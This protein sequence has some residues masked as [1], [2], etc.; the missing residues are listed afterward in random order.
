MLNAVATANA[1]DDHDD[2]QQTITSGFLLLAAL[3]SVFAA[4]L[5]FFLPALGRIVLESGLP[6][7]TL[8]PAM[9]G[10]T[11]FAVYALLA[12]PLTTGDRIATAL[13][14]G[15]VLNLI[16]ACILIVTV[17]AV[18]AVIRAGGG[19]VSLC[20]A[21]ILPGL[22]GS[23]M[24]WLIVT[25]NR[26]WLLPQI[27]QFTWHRSQA[28]LHSGIGFFVIQL[29]GAIG[30]N[31]DTLIVAKGLGPAAAAE[32][33]L[34]S[35][36]FSIALVIGNI[37]LSP[38]WPAYAD[39]ASRGELSWARRALTISLV[40]SAGLGGFLA[41]SLFLVSGWL[42]P[43]WL[44]DGYAVNGTLVAMMAVWTTLSLVGTAIAMFWN[45]MHW[46]RLQCIMG[47][48]F[49]SVS[50]PLKL[51]L[52][53]GSTIDRFVLINIVCFLVLELVPGVACTFLLLRN[54]ATRRSQISA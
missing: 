29:I 22:I 2:V 19:F 15:F 49:L 1:R 20:S 6:E 35:R 12:M 11:V 18:Y 31:M 37:V 36:Y 4:A 45:G 43:L 21:S 50:L 5:F 51:W 10:L 42:V 40:S 38:L 14:E 28:L 53:R 46:L 27:N 39:A 52:C 17:G 41:A 9:G 16:R 54:A 23:C 25:R 32:L 47:T 48:L 33:A 34:A 8:K 44:G 7:T 13:Q 30:F 3:A 24:T 26:P